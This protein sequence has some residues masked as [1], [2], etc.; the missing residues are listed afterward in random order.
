M[1][2]P[3]L[4]CNQCLISPCTTDTFSTRPYPHHRPPKDRRLLRSTS[5]TQRHSCI[6][7]GN[8]PYFAT[9]AV[10]GILGGAVW[11]LRALWGLFRNDW[12]FCRKYTRR[13]TIH[14]EG[15]RKCIGRTEEC[16]I[17]C[18]SGACQTVD[19][20]RDYTGTFFGVACVNHAGLQVRVGTTT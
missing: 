17:T 18:L 5:K 4:D 15:F 19:D 16:G 10:G 20:L 12:H 7:R 9:V 14:P 1:I 13:R 2:I 8:S 11:N 3:S 6:R